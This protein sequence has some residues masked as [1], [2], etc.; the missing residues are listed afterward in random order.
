[1]GG[2]HSDVLSHDIMTIIN[3]NVHLFQNSQEMEFQMVSPTE[4]IADV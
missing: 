2:I 1:M 3:R 4:E